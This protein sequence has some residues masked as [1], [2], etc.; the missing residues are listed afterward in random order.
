MPNWPEFMPAPVDDDIAIGA[1]IGAVLRTS[2]DA[3][4]AKQRPRFTAAP[5]PVTLVFKPIS[6][7]NFTAFEAFYENDLSYGALDFHMQHP[8]TDVTQ[9]FRFVASQEPW[10]MTPIGKDAYRLSVNLERL[11]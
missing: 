1:P 8:I 3:G 7:A 11:P 4:P 9:R 2:M 6:A 10:R 5:Q